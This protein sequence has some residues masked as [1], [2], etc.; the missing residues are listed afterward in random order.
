VASACAGNHTA[1][2]YMEDDDFLT[3][4]ALL[5]WADD[6]AALAAIGFTRSFVR[7]ETLP[8]TGAWVS[9]TCSACTSVRWWWTRLEVAF[10]AAERP[11]R[12]T[13]RVP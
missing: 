10:A 2:M 6:E 5:S 13:R 4:E 1:M 8:E 7:I 9:M 11:V 3:W 12:A